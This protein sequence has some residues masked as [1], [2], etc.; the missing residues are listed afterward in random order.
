MAE[1]TIATMGSG[2][3]GN[4]PLAPLGARANGRR[5]CPHVQQGRFS[6]NG[7][8]GQQRSRRGA[9]IVIESD[10]ISSYSSTRRAQDSRT[11]D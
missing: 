2:N 8:F 6:S 10:T 1:A 9:R 3:P 5:G 4:T 7:A 11:V